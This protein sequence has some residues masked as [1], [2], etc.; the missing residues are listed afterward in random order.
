MLLMINQKKKAGQKLNE[1]TVRKKYVFRN[2]KERDAVLG[3][4]SPIDISPSQRRTSD[5]GPEEG[6]FI[7]CI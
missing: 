6:I 7:T 1:C 5:I 2:A 4:F 3:M